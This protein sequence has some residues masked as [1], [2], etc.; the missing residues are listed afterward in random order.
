MVVITGKKNAQALGIA[1]KMN[2]IKNLNCY[3]TFG[4]RGYSTCHCPLVDFDFFWSKQI[5]L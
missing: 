1:N 4:I 5:E 3:L 2:L